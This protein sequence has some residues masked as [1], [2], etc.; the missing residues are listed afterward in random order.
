MVA[1]KFGQTVDGNQQQFLNLVVHPNSGVPTPAPI[2]G[3][4]WYDT[5]TGKFMYR[6]GIAAANVDLRARATHT[7]SQAASTISDLAA[8]VQAYRLDQFS[9]PTAGLNVN[10]QRLISVA[11]PTTG[12]DG[13]N[14]DYVDTALAN[15][16]AGIH[17]KDPVRVAA[18]ANGTLATA[19]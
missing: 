6:D 2:S 13:A 18:T 5:A 1:Y 9:A 10:G 3:Q 7:G 11:T 8:V 19:F 17:F 14:R 12:T 16:L 15:G 4:V